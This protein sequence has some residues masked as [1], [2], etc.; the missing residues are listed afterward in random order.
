MNSLEVIFIAINQLISQI[1]MV[2]PKLI[3]ALLIWYIGKYLIS[4][5]NKVI[6]KIDLKGTTIDDK[7]IETVSVIINFAGR[8]ILALIILDYLGIGSSV[9]SAIAQGITFAV[10]IALGLSFGRALEPD[11]KRIVENLREFFHK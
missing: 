6:K 8:V 4:L 3:I 5:A 11:A 1:I 7:A 9:I 10:A 2:L